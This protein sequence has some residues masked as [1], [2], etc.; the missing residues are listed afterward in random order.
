MMMNRL[1]STLLIL[2]LVTICLHILAAALIPFLPWAIAVLVF[3][4][5]ASLLF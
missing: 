2:V 1:R 5:I 4:L 3:L